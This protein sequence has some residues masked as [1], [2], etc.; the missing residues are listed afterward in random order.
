MTRPCAPV[1]N[2]L[3]FQGMAFPVAAVIGFLLFF[4]RSIGVSATST[5]MNS[6]SWSSIRSFF[7]PATVKACEV[8]KISSTRRIVRHTLDSWRP[9]L[10]AIWKKVRYRAP[11]FQSHQDLIF[12]GKLWRSSALDSGLRRMVTH[13]RDHPVKSFGFDSAVSFEEC[14]SSVFNLFVA[15]S[16]VLL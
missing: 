4:G 2:H 16:G 15:H 12:D 10:L 14:G 1:D 13:D 9:Q 5:I 3:A 11:V 8:V 6:I 7:L